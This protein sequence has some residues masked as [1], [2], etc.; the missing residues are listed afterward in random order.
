MSEKRLRVDIGEIQ[1]LIQEKE[2]KDVTWVSKKEQLADGL[3]KRDVCMDNLMN[4]L[5][6][7]R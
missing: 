6:V 3:T 5:S 1:R 7:E 2:V 4:I